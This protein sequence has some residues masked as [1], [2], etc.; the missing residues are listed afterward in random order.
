MPKS[1]RDW[2]DRV[3]GYR[4]LAQFIAGECRNY[5]RSKGKGVSPQEREGICLRL[6]SRAG[7][8]AA[9][10]PA[11][12]VLQWRDAVEKW[13][14]P[15][16]PALTPP[17]RTCRA[18]IDSIACAPAELTPR[19]RR[20]VF[21][22]LAKC[23]KEHC[24]VDKETSGQGTCS[25]FE[26]ALRPILPPDLAAE[27]DRWRQQQEKEHGIVRRSDGGRPPGQSR[28]TPRR[29][30]ARARAARRSQGQ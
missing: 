28:R 10:E 1:K 11:C 24:T 26:E 30:V 14:G 18:K 22:A 13:D 5:H 20:I 27:Y 21:T 4:T 7:A 2:R 25:W 3:N 29:A 19:L 16:G 6:V 8:D 23:E 17:C 9:P 12:D 15:L